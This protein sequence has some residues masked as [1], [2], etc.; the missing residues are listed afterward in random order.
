MMFF[1][2]FNSIFHDYKQLLASEVSL[3]DVLNLMNSIAPGS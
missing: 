3:L 1:S 2:P